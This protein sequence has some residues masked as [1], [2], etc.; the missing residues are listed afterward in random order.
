MWSAEV[1]QQNST[2]MHIATLYATTRAAGARPTM[3]HKVPRNEKSLVCFI[4]ELVGTTVVI[5]CRDDVAI[6]GQLEHC[7]DEMHCTL[8]SAIR[9]TP[10]GEKTRLDRVFVRARMIRYVHFAPSIDPAAHMEQKRLDWFE[11]SRHYARKA[12]FGPKNAAKPSTGT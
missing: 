7:D 1:L 5:E 4:Q 2:T 12:V 10:E 9:V 6:R 8:T 3:K 11:A